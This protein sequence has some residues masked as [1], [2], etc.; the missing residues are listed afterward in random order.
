MAPK[1]YRQKIKQQKQ[2]QQTP[3]PIKK[4]KSNS[5]KSVF[6]AIGVIAVIIIIVGA[7]A[8]SGLMGGNQGTTTNPTNSPGATTIPASDDPYANST[9]V[10]FHTSMG[11][12]TVALRNDMPITTGNFL[13]MVRQGVYDGTTFHRVIEGF[14]IQSG[15]PANGSELPTIQDEFTSTNHNYNMTIAMANTGAANSGSSQFFINTANNNNRYSTFDSTY[16][17]FGKIIYGDDVVMAISHVA[18][19]DTTNYVPVQDVTILDARVL[20]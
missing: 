14:M 8:A 15:I 17:A 9:Y 11:N 4:R 3:K 16:P 18:V 2:S 19:K 5:N 1:K 6:I 13:N 12:F 7:L 20:N 10:F